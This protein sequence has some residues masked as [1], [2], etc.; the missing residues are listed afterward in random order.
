M[1]KKHQLDELETRVHAL[2]R[3]VAMVIDVLKDE[4][5][6]TDSYGLIKRL[7]KTLALPAM[8]KRLDN[9]KERIGLGK[10]EYEK[11][12]DDAREWDQ[13]RKK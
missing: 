10:G 6:K 3:T 5:E 4:M 8:R 11:A 9:A 7:R 12:L 2:E 13:R 1:T